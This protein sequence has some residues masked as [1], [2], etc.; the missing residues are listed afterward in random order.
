MFRVDAE[1]FGGEEIGIGGGLG[2][3]IIA[4]ADEGV[5]EGEEAEGFEGFDDRLAGAAGDD[6]EGDFAV[7]EADLL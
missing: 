4:R 1:A 6:G 7:L 2:S 5:E 3:P